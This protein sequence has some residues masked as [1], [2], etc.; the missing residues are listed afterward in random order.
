MGDPDVMPA[1]LEKHDIHVA[2]NHH[3]RLSLQIAFSGM[4]QTDMKLDVCCLDIRHE[5][6]SSSPHITTYNS[7]YTTAVV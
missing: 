4:Y 6:L 7:A 3:A 2:N 5:V 1:E